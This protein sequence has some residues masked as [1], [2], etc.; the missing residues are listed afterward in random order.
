MR[1]LRPVLHRFSPWYKIL[2]TIN[3]FLYYLVPKGLYQPKASLA[4][5][6]LSHILIID[7]DDDSPMYKFIGCSIFVFYI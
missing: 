4:G 6:S 5:K 1:P 7:D 3:Q 2:G